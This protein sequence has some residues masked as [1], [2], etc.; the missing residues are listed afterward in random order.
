MFLFESVFKTLKRFFF[1]NTLLKTV[2]VGKGRQGDGDAWK[3]NLADSNFGIL[4]SEPSN[5]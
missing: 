5:W 3:H 4:I 1:K 2:T